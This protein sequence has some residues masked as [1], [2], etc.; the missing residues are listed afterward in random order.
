VST[1]PHM[2]GNEINHLHDP[3]GLYELD[4]SIAAKPFQH[5]PFLPP[6]PFEEKP[7]QA[8]ILRP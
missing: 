2:A 8:W 1:C 6:C 3:C 5:N 4:L 7:W